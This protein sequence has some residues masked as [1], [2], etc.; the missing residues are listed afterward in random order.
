VLTNLGRNTRTRSTRAPTSATSPNTIDPNYHANRDN[1]FILGLDHELR[2]NFAVG[3]AYVPETNDYPTWNAR[4]GM[5]S[6]DYAVMARPRSAQ[7]RL[8]YARIRRRS[9]RVAAAASW[10]TGRI[11]IAYQGFEFTLNKRLSNRWM[12]RWRS[13]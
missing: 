13:R 7:G 11:T 9:M 3:A 8:V 10:R 4:I 5:T 12:S 6:A 2:P 1:E